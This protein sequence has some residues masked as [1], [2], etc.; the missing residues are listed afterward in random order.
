MVC[1]LYSALEDV[2]VTIAGETRVHRVVVIKGDGIGPEL[3]D[4]ALLVLQAV[5]RRIGD[6]HLELD[7]REGGA[8]LY[9]R[10][11]FNLAPEMK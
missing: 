10:E 5:E 7:F 9:Q 8:A 1:R 3:V 2:A 11:G 6:F 4:G